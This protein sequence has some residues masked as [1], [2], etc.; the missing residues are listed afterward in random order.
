MDV[1][2]ESVHTSDDEDIGDIEAINRDFIVVKRGYV[3]VHYYYIPMNKVE[4]WDGHV[5]WLK[6]TEKEV[7]NNYQRDRSPDPTNY[8]IQGHSYADAKPFTTSYFPQMPI[9]EAKGR[10]MPSITSVEKTRAEALGAKQTTQIHQVMHICPLCNAEFK[11]EDELT[12][13]VTAR[14]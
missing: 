10:T 2:N 12:T 1:T 9:I 4:G 8:Y 3:H 5:V 14:H 11:S 7:K 6:I 13:H